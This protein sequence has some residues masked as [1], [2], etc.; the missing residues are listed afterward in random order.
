MPE[1]GA[2]GFYGLLHRANGDECTAIW[3]LDIVMNLGRLGEDREIRERAT[4]AGHYK[5]LLTNIARCPA[6][7]SRELV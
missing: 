4:L 2:K 6:S 5:T 3:K 1:D 7:S